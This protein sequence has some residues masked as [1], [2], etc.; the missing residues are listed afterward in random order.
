MKEDKINKIISKLRVAE[1]V[2]KGGMDGL[3]NEWEDFALGE[4]IEGYK[5]TI[6]YCQV[7]KVQFSLTNLIK[8]SNLF[9]PKSSF[10]S[11]F[12][13]GVFPLSS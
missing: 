1:H 7:D 6:G 9:L 8:F 3:I 11:A 4:C 10:I 2:K 13:A 5:L 12:S